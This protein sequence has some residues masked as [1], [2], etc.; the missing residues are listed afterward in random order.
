M[1]HCKEFKTCK[2]CGQI[3]KLE[4]FRNQSSSYDGKKLYCRKCDD[5]YNKMRYKLNKE[6]RILQIQKWQ[7]KNQDK[8]KNYIRKHRQKI[9]Q[10]YSEI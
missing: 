2:K 1:N 5:E 8:V 9:K 10:N 6:Y 4:Q 7:S 3:K